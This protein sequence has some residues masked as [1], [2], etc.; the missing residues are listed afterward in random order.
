M[1]I[2]RGPLP[3]SWL[4]TTVCSIAGLVI[5][6]E[7]LLVIAFLIDGAWAEAIGVAVSMVIFGLF[8]QHGLYLRDVMKRWAKSRA[9]AADAQ[10]NQ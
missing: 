6:A 5:L 9:V 4:F 8:L 10:R 2:I 1:D 3:P 7:A